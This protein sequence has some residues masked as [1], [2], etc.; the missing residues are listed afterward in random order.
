MGKQ[1]QLGLGG[2]LIWKIKDDMRNFKNLTMG[3][4]V[5]MGR[6]TFQSIGKAL[7]GRTNVVVS[8]N[9]NLN[10]DGCIK[11]AS[12][13]EALDFVKN[14]GEPELFIIGGAIVY[15]FF[16]KNKLVDRMYLTE[17][18]YDENADVFFPEFV[19][20]DWVLTNISNFEK[21]SGNEYSGKIFVLDRKNQNYYLTSHTHPPLAIK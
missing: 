13:E 17:V 12:F 5:L 1:R 15:D 14:T 7:P 18:D 10:F 2:K 16:I 4:H 11:F 6:V 3:H 9:T 8:R 19:I 20:D 21:N